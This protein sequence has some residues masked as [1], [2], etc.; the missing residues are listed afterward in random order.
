M[1]KQVRAL[2]RGLDL[3]EGLNENDGADIASLAERTGLPRGTAYRMME[4]L[5]AKGFVTKGPDGASYW[6][7]KKVRVLSSG[8]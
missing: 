8:F 5:I 4:T 7:T 6:L 2:E 1:V 3:L